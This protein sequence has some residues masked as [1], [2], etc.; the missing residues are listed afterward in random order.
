MHRAS[1]RRH[2]GGGAC[3]IRFRCAGCDHFR[4]DVSYLPDLTAYLDDLLRTRERLA[5]AID[6]IDDWAQAD[7]HPCPAKKSPASGSLIRRIEGRHRRVACRRA[8]PGSMA[9]TVNPQSTARSSLGCRPSALESR[10]D[11]S[12]EGKALA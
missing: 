3:P 8:C 7:A 11:H 1:Q 6:G 12:P 5:A 4:T 10:P 2:A 9:V